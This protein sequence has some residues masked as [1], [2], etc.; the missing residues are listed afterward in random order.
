MNERS[1]KRKLSL[2]AKQ[3]YW[4]FPLLLIGGCQTI[5]D[6]ANS[7]Q[8]PSLSVD[9]VRVTGFNFQ[10]MQLTYDIKVDNPNAATLQMLGYDYN[11]D[12]NGNSFIN[13]DQTKRVTVGASG[14][15]IIQVPMTLNFSDVYQAINGLAQEKKTAYNFASN[16][17]FELPVLGETEI[18]VK[19]KGSIPLLKLPELNVS[20][21]Q[22][23]N[24]SLNG[25]DV[26]LK[27]QFDNPNG[28]GLNINQLN[29]DL[30]VNGNQWAD[31]TALQDVNI[32]EDGVT[33]LNIPISL[34]IAQIG[35]S[36]YRILSGSE[37]VDYQLKGNFG[38]N[39]LHELLGSTNFDFNRDGQIPIS[40]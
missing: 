26:N 36:A 12:L 3:I 23:Q 30:V 5:Q 31:G 29:Y 7:I 40:R 15:S 6:L 13:G 35:T 8:K 11:L 34:N 27:L 28:F 24:L 22:L 17:R 21:V 37:S 16:L 14:E 4:L 25:A 10:E 32:K 18:P 38:F 20:N 1:G 19:K 2:A 9:D 33:E 39:A